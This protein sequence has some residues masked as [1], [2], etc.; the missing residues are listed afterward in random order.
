MS[1]AS[2]AV[3]AGTELVP[4]RQSHIAATY[5]WIQSPKLR[6]DFLLQGEITWEGH[7]RYFERLLSDPT[8]AI[9]AI[10]FDGS[11]VGNCGFKH[12]DRERRRGEL[13]IYLGSYDHHGKGIG[14][15]ATAALL[16]KGFG[17]LS[18]EVIYLHVAQFNQKAAALYER[19]GFA[20][21]PCDGCGE[22]G[23]RSTTILHM[24]LTR[25]RWLVPNQRGI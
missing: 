13:W 9:Y 12:I 18:L 8:Q 7:L 22:W 19:S 10:C 17:E 20:V 4:F 25:D 14:R 5:Q 1:E 3:R 2:A 24:E 15:D 21:T 6:R 23:E 11:H 16:D